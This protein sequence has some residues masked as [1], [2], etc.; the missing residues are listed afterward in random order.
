MK[1][2]GFS[3]KPQ[4][5]G[6]YHPL[7]RFYGTKEV[8]KYP[9]GTVKPQPGSW[10]I[11]CEVRLKVGRGRMTFLPFEL[12]LTRPGGWR[13]YNLVPVDREG[14]EIWH[15]D[16]EIIF[17]REMTGMFEEIDLPTLLL[18]NLEMKGVIEPG[19]LHD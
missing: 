2:K 9:D 14:Q 4:G 7:W 6:P 16:N 15:P 5:E 12:E 13:F 19:Q 1:V 8:F 11:V 10:E 17:P 3:I 18:Y